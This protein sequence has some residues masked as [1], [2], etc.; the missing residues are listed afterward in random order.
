MSGDLYYTTDPVDSAAVRLA[1]MLPPGWS[2]MLDTDALWGWFG[3]E[4]YDSVRVPGMVIATRRNHGMAPGPEFE[5]RAMFAGAVKRT[6]L[7]LNRLP[8]PPAFRSVR[9][10]ID[11]P[12][13]EDLYVAQH[14]L[15]ERLRDVCLESDGEPA[16]VSTIRGF[17]PRGGG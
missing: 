8:M 13:G 1:R 14:R 11:Y 3:G 16:M 7:A 2:L 10:S 12:A 17:G 9:V 5:E 6:P 4:N 15:G